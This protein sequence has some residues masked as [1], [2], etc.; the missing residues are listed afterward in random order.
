MPGSV[1][2]QVGVASRSFPAFPQLPLH[3]VKGRAV[4]VVGPRFPAV[5]VRRAVVVVAATL[6][7]VRP[8]GVMLPPV[9]LLRGRVDG[10]RDGLASEAAP[11]GTGD[12]SDRCSDRRPDRAAQ[13]SPGRRPLDRR[14]GRPEGRAPGSPAER[15][16]DA[17][18]DRVRTGF[19]AERVAVLVPGLVVTLARRHEM[20]LSE[21]EDALPRPAIGLTFA[22]PGGAD[23]REAASAV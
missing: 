21:M 14:A 12:H 9:G 19:P 2:G 18:A 11:D 16:P 22:S 10:L 20:L 5:T 15:C 8:A 17:G 23:V 13:G 3:V 4:L 1:P 7:D 6:L